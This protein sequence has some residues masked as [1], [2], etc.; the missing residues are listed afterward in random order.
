MGEK[1]G[2]E[3]QAGMMQIKLQGKTTRKEGQVEGFHLLGSLKEGSA[4][5]RESSSQSAVRG[6]PCFLGKGLFSMFLSQWLGASRGKHSLTAIPEHSSPWSTTFPVVGGHAHSHGSQGATRVIFL[7]G[8]LH[9]SP[10]LKHLPRLPSVFR[11]KSQV[12]W[13]RGGHLPLLLSCPPIL[14][15]TQ[16]R[17]ADP[18]CP[19]TRYPFT[20]PRPCPP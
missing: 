4:G 6:V 9:A 15:P 17:W 20:P 16:P 13:G 1:T 19:R 12:L 5:I 14:M 8:N 3:W 7:K 2:R 10:L 18:C 11:L